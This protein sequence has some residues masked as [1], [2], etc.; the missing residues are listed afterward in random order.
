M[1]DSTLDWFVHDRFGLF[2]H[3]GLYSLGARHEWLMNRERIQVAEYEKYARHFEPDLYDPAEWAEQA[4]RAGMK[5]VVLTTKH[6]EGFCLWDSKL[7][8]YT[9]MNTPYGKDVVRE[10]VDAVR[11]AGLKVGFYHSLIDWH[12]PDFPIDGHHPRRDDADAAAQNE[13]RDIA[14]YRD[15]L[16][17]QVRELLT[18]YGQID[19]LFFDFSYEHSDHADIWGGKGAAAWAS[20][21]LL[22]LVRELQPGI[23]VND[24]LG[25][26]GDFVT[27]EQYQP[28]APMEVDGMLVP[29]EACQTINGSWGYYRDNHNDKSADMLVRMLIDGVSKNGNLLLNVGPTGRG[30]FDPT[31]SAT[32]ERIGTWMRRHSR[33]IYGA[34]PSDF[35]PPA[36]VRYTQRGNRLYAH[37]FAWPFEN[38]HL[39]GLAGKVEYAQ[40][41]DDASELGMR[42]IDPSLRAQNT[43]I[44][45][46]PEG[47]LTIT[48]PVTRPDVIVPVVELF[49]RD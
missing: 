31:A 40:L 1:S 17:G 45:G 37:L 21:E 3:W 41:L 20:E 48:L 6:H 42:V 16:H 27:P 30:D 4:K 12:H 47:T 15:Y 13:H 49:L 26:P 38:L 24:R 9:V 33:S 29:W 14:R 18:E 43:G 7:T 28:T 39:P 8:D 44:G 32:L 34:G 35:T 11:G 19:Y 25:I 10:Y 46:Q 36:D 2:V 23:L 22:A 5:Y